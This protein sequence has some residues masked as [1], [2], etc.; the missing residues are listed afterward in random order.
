MPLIQVISVGEWV[1]LQAARPSRLQ[2]R[3]DTLHGNGADAASEEK[4]P[5]PAEG[6]PRQVTGAQDA[7]RRSADRAPKKPRPDAEG[8]L[9]QHIQTPPGL[10]GPAMQTGLPAAALGQEGSRRDRWAAL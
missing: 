3:H 8:V 4:A 7:R 5:G 1:D 10:G 2:A 9:S 6:E